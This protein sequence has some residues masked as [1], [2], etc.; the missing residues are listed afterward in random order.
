MIKLGL[1]DTDLQALIALLRQPHWIKV[2]IQILD[3]N[4][5][6]M[7]DITDRLLS[8]Q[9]NFDTS[10]DV[11]RTLEMELS[12]PDATLSINPDSP[13][14]GAVFVNR[15]IKVVYSVAPPKPDKWY[16]IPLFVGPITGLKRTGLSCSVTA[17]GKDS[18]AYSSIWS[19]RTFK[20]N[21]KISD[22]IVLILKNMLGETKLDVPS[23]DR[24]TDKEVV[25][26]TSVVPW[27][28]L[29]KLAGSLGLFA[30]YDGRGIF[31]ARRPPRTAT[32]TFDGR[33]V[34]SDI[35]FT[36]DPT[37][38]I[39][40]VQVIGGKPKGKKNKVS[41]RAVAPNGHP[42]SPAKLGRNGVP[43]YYTR[44]IEDGSL[45]TDRACKARAKDE[46]DRGLKESINIEFDA[47]PNP[48][49][50]EGDIFRVN[51]DEVKMTGKLVQWAIPL[52]HEGQM[53]VGV[54]KKVSFKVNRKGSSKGKHRGR[55]G[56]PRS[57]GKGGRRG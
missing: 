25:V 16:D 28:L 35:T 26:G 55:S 52:T 13:E 34:T 41:A 47:L 53:S 20:K 33:N 14:D 17:S 22:I 46:L 11:I 42:L 1:K 19:G 6:V 48:L 30:F 7:S 38:I 50:E 36:Y 29:R 12:D 45:K 56:R 31:Q 49:M 15:M 39:N 32:H 21:Q 3:M 24:R 44:V 18:L 51:T 40:A 10:A 37:T 9:V 54:I 27:P 5:K 4:H 57:G 8:G 23:K 2:T 43:R